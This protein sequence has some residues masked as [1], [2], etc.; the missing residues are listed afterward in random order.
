MQFMRSFHGAYGISAPEVGL[1]GCR[2]SGGLYM[3]SRSSVAFL[4]CIE[5]SFS[6]VLDCVQCNKEYLQFLLNSCVVLYF[7]V[8]DNI[9]DALN[10]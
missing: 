7:L 6:F 10:V 5:C 4:F 3:M 1:Y 2:G 9:H 8:L